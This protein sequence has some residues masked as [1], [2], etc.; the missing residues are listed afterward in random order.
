VLTAVMF[1]EKSGLKPGH[2]SSS[3]AALR[4]IRRSTS[5]GRQVGRANPVERVV[6]P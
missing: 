3:G 1:D 2:E 5:S 4:T 6:G